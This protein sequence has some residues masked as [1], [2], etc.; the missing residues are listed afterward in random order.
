M[1]HRFAICGIAFIVA[2]GSQAPA[3]PGARVPSA[4][5][6]SLATSGLALSAYAVL[7]TVQVDGPVRIVAALRAGDEPMLVSNLPEHYTFLI[8]GPSGDTIPSTAEPYE[9]G[10]YSD[11]PRLS[12]PRNGFVGQIIDLACVVPHYGG[13]GV[14][15]RPCMF[16]FP[17]SEQG[18][19][20]IVV[21]FRA[22]T[23]ASNASA[24]LVDLYSSPIAV[25]VR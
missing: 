4:L 12:I 18:V 14:S 7:D 25:T 2:C 17:F 6:D 15:E 16:R 24:G 3:N 23:G 8:V 11:D 9:S 21:R 13:Q 20:K 22:A 19:Y 1:R 5:S 10:I